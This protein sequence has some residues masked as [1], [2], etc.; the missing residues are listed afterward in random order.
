MQVNFRPKFPLKSTNIVF[1]VLL[2]AIGPFSPARKSS[3]SLD[4][5][6]PV[7][8]TDG[9]HLGD[10]FWLPKT[11]IYGD[12]SADKTIY[13]VGDSHAAQWLPGLINA[14]NERHWK[15]RSMTKSGCALADLA[16]SAEC[17]RW[18][19]EVLAQVEDNKP[20]LVIVSNLTNA[21]FALNPNELQHSNSF[22]KIKQILS[23]KTRHFSLQENYDVKFLLGFQRAISLLVRYSKVVV[24]EDTPYPNFN[25]TSCLYQN[26]SDSCNFLNSTSLL[27]LKTETTARKSGASWIPISNNFCSPVICHAELNGVNLFRDSSHISQFASIYYFPSYILA[28]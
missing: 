18:N 24:I 17:T 27:T 3:L 20:D 15:V 1:L 11:C 8:Y 9:C 7:S 10:K 22:N 12:L 26:G 2:L 21:D 14:A 13:L 25:I 6:M 16:I 19:M 28:D 5:N 4:L 23:K